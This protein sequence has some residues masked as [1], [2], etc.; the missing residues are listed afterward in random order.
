MSKKNFQ[1]LVAKVA[2]HEVFGQFRFITTD[3]GEIY[4]V[5]VDVCKVLGIKNHRDAVSG[6]DGDEKDYVGITD[7]IGRN[8]QTLVV[9][10]SGLY[11]LVFQSRKPAAKKFRK[12][13]TSEVLPSIRKNGYYS[14]LKKKIVTHQNITFFDEKDN[15]EFTLID[16]DDATIEYDEHGNISV[17]YNEQLKAVADSNGDFHIQNCYGKLLTS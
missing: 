11:S 1:A 17:I 5:A 2:A 6:L 10:E 14:V 13:V 9:N 12:W 7:A 16:I 3:D 15:G 4:F 8:R